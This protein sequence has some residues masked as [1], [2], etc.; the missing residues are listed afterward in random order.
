MGMQIQKLEAQKLKNRTMLVT[1]DVTS[2]LLLRLGLH[3]ISYL[4]SKIRVA[5]EV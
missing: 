4:S 2:D 1:P 3:E 5:A